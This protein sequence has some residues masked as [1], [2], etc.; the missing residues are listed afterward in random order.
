VY[1]SVATSDFDLRQVNSEM[2]IVLS[3]TNKMCDADIQ[4]GL[5]NVS[6]VF[7]ITVS[8]IDQF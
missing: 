5:N 8:N 3:V 1:I 2:E 6:Q 4:G 7:V